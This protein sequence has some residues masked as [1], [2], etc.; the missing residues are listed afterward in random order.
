MDGRAVLGQE[1]GRGSADPGGG[2]GDEGD[3]AFQLAIW[4]AFQKLAAQGPTLSPVRA[5]SRTKQEWEGAGE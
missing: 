2:T 5:G 3:S 4:S 1:P